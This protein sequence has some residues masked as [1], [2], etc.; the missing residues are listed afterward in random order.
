MK[1]A[2]I[3]IIILSIFCITCNRVES[4]PE[5]P[6]CLNDYF[7]YINGQSLKYTN[8][9]YD[10]L[11]FFV[12][13]AGI[14]SE[15][16]FAYRGLV[17]GNYCSRYASIS[18]NSTQDEQGINCHCHVK[19]EGSLDKVGRVVVNIIFY[20]E[21]HG[22]EYLTIEP[23]KKSCSYK[24]LSKYLEDTYTIENVNNKSIKRVVIVK[25][26]GIVSYTT[27]DGEEWKLVE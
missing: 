14:Y 2:D 26:K 23:L 22:S 21:L 8:S 9:Q 7:P 3:I 15:S 10:T 24:K 20:N 4:C 25:G 12:A 5:F 19:A 13:E 17:K 27:A 6:S 18:I 11:D 1:K 16:D